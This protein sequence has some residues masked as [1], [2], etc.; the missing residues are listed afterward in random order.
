LQIE[1]RK[2]KLEKLKQTD[3]DKAKKIVE[4]QNW[5]SA[6][7]KAQGIK[8]QDDEKLLKKTIKRKEQKKEKSKKEW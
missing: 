3:G 7:A 2:A 5:N 4:K 6:L 1:S 8:L